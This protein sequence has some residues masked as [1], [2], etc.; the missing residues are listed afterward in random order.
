MALSAKR[1]KIAGPPTTQVKAHFQL[2]TVAMD[3]IYIVAIVLAVV[4]FIFRKQLSSAA[5]FLSSSAHAFAKEY[6]DVYTEEDTKAE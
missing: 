4:G 1:N 5:S 6:N 3:T 2:S